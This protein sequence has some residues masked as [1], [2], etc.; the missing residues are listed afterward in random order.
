MSLNT[1]A[2]LKTAI[3]TWLHRAD[4]ASYTDD[5]VT[6]ADARIGREIRSRYQQ[7]RSTSTVS[8]YLSLPSDFLALR[9]L[10]I[11]SGGVIT[12]LQYLTPDA[13]LTMYPTTS[14]APPKH[15]TI[16]GDE[17]RFGPLPSES[18]T[19]ELWYFKKF[20]ALAVETN[21]LF[22]ANPDLWLYASLCA[23][24][25]FLKNDSRVMLWESQYTAVRN[26]VNQTEDAAVRTSDMQVVAA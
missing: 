5:F 12:K 14:T 21:D 8:S 18:S 22:L 20:S 1:Y 3:G 24:T 15:F 4:L 19:A 13:L 11:T 17:V 25:P 6:I 16:I 10:W 26:Q 9:S 23:A 7:Q 2:G